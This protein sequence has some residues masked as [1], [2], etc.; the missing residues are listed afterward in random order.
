MNALYALGMTVR[1]WSAITVVYTGIQNQWTG[2]SSCEPEFA[3]TQDCYKSRLIRCFV[4]LIYV[5]Y[6]SNR[7]KLV[8]RIS[9]LPIDSDLND[10]RGRFAD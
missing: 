3:N 1:T 6:Q 2:P 8:T 10:I 5:L 9:Q 4:L 7:K